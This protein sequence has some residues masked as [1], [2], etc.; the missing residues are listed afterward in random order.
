[1]QALEIIA[2]I[3]SIALMMLLVGVAIVRWRGLKP[4]AQHTSGAVGMENVLVEGKRRNSFT[5][6]TTS[7]PDRIA[8]DRAQKFR[9]RANSST[10][11]VPEFRLS[12][13]YKDK[14]IYKT[15]QRHPGFAEFERRNS[16]RFSEDRTS[17]TNS[18]HEEEPG[19]SN[20]VEIANFNNSS[21]ASQKSNAIPEEK[22]DGNVSSCNDDDNQLVLFDADAGKDEPQTALSSPVA[23][24]CDAV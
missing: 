20:Y 1:M 3:V 16:R 15:L 21:V 14:N 5:S 8:A 4:D 2:I 24:V 19:C 6:M 10:V 13:K 7:P 18:I 12:N 11:G 23:D 17:N 22:D 9:D